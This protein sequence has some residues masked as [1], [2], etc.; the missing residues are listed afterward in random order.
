MELKSFLKIINKLNS[1]GPNPKFAST[2]IILAYIVIATNKIGR[3]RLSKVIGI[4]EGS[5]RTLLKI[6]VKLNLITITTE[7]CELTNNGI[8]LYEELKNIISEWKELPVGKLTIDK[9]NIIIKV[10]NC[11][12]LIK[13]GIIERDAGIVV[14]ATGIISLIVKNN[15]FCIPGGS[16]NCEKEYPD[17]I[18]DELKTKFILSNNDVIIISGSKDIHSA[19]YGA[20][21][22]SLKLIYKKLEV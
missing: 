6:L 11:G 5:V 22:G 13:H 19:I 10:R 17:I 20:I 12:H 1:L 9:H 7:G 4:G 16:N 21:A 14:G 3:A 2:H 15:K 18:W 8:K